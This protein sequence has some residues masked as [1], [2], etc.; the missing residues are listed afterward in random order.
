[1]EYYLIGLCLS[2]IV[3]LLFKLRNLQ[4]RF[5]DIMTGFFKRLGDNYTEL[6][7]RLE[8]LGLRVSHVERGL[9]SKLNASTFHSLADNV[10][11]IDLELYG[12]HQR[13]KDGPIVYADTTKGKQM[14][15]KHAAKKPKKPKKK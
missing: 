13:L 11:R 3:L 5:G 8:A 10:K 9:Q 12:Y 15:A 4:R 1:M 6:D 2:L 14:K 7:D